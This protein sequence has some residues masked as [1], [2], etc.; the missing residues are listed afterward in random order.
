MAFLKC[1]ESKKAK[2]RSLRQLLQVI[3]AGAAGGCDL[4]I[5][6]NDNGQPEGQPL[7]NT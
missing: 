3:G 5:F 7:L 6:E 1:F 2:D 4:L